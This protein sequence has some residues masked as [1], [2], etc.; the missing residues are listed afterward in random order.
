MMNF[1]RKVSAGVT[2]MFLS[3][4]AWGGQRDTLLLTVDELFR[5][6]MEMSLVL[7]ADTLDC[8]MAGQSLRS[9]RLAQA[10][11]VEVGLT[12]GYLGQPVVFLHGLEDATWP[13]SPDWSQNYSVDVTQPVYQGGR[14]RRVIRR[15]EMEHDIAGLQISA[16]ASDIRLS[17]MEQYLNLFCLYKEQDVMRQNI[18]E[19][20]RRL[21]DIIRM[22]EEGLITNNDVLR[23]ELQ[24]SNDRISLK[25][26]ENSI[27]LASQQLD[28]LL[29]LDEQLLIVPDTSALRPALLDETFETCL[30][31]AYDADPSVRLA[32]QRVA[33][34][35]NEVKIACSD[36]FPT[37]SLYAGNTLARPISRTMADMFCNSWS[38]GLSI[39]YP[40]SSIYR[41]RTNVIP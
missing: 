7:Q 24:L 39:S 8:L 38:I 23:S 4:L 35:E 17:L 16:D 2:A 33:L 19:S 5:M 31:K 21:Q 15:A 12:G 6:G 18:S 40:I 37:I 11:D 36:Y 25:R 3:C 9:A 32:R 29:G 13:E 26:T 41:N 10:P 30:M 1:V 22:K 34:A 27:I 20:E 14:I 28:I